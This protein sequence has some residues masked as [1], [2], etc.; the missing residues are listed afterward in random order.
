[1]RV[2]IQRVSTAAVTIDA[3]SYRAVINNGIVI[4]L[5]IK[6]D[7]KEE[8]AIYLADK[9]INLRIFDDEKGKMNKSLRDVNGEILVI[10]QFTIYGEVSRGNRPSFSE[11]AKG[12][13]AIPLYQKFIS[14]LKFIL[15]DEQVK[16]G[17]FGALMRVDIRNEGPVTITIDSV[18]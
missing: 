11:A 16:A 8:D 4:L 9:C 12:D 1:M 14:R 3:E 7:D 10:S 18:R 17:K 2:I 5:G 15:G 6:G 13:I